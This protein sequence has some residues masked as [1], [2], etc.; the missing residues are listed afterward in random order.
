MRKVKIIMPFVSQAYLA[1]APF[2]EQQ[3]FHKHNITLGYH[4]ETFEDFYVHDADRYK[5]VYIEGKPGSGKS[6]E[7]QNMVLQDAA[8]GRA[9]IVIDPHMDLVDKCIATLDP[10]VLPRVFVLDMTDEQY[11]FGI[12][13]FNTAAFTSD[14]DKTQVVDRI[15]HIFELLWPDVLSQANL[16]RYLRHI[17]LVFLDNPGATLP[18]MYDFL[19]DDGYRRKLLANVTDKGVRQFWQFNYDSLQPQTRLG[20][21]QPL[22]GRL[23]QMFSG[24]QLVKNI[25][26]QQKNSINFREAIEE[27]RIIF[28]KLPLKIVPED[29]RLIGTL[30][31][32]QIH[33]TLFSF[34]DIPDG[35]RPGVS[36]FIDEFQNFVTNDVAELITQGRKYG[37]RITI[38][39]QSR[40][41]L[42]KEM[43][44]AT[45][46]THTQVVFQSTPED[47]RELAHLFPPPNEGIKPEDIDS[48]PTETLAAHAN[49]YPPAIQDFIEWYV[50][51]IGLQAVGAHGN[52]IDIRDAGHSAFSIA[53]DMLDGGR[54]QSIK[55][56]NPIPVLDY[57]LQ[58]VMVYGDA[59]FPIPAAAVRGFANC[60]HTFWQQVAWM[61]DKNKRLHRDIAGLRVPAHLAVQTAEGWQWTRPPDS[62]SEQ[63]LHLLFHIR[64][65]M[66]YL[67][68]HPLGKETTVSTADVGKMLNQLP[69]RCAWVRSG[70]HTG[71]IFTNDTPQPDGTAKDRMDYVRDHTRDVY[72]VDRNKINQPV[73]STTQAGPKVA[74]P[75]PLQTTPP[76]PIADDD[77]QTEP[78]LPVVKA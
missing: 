45:M 50:L 64:A 11:P 6:G 38:A 1:A 8:A 5:A 20:K 66:Q 49:M 21:V 63:L 35:K 77:E 16:P 62:A 19:L 48:H 37:M 53:S 36:L 43:R 32:A 58:M 34:V 76:A 29:A 46:N 69:P 68:A 23:E 25:L 74:N 57:L 72:C 24:R 51:P 30:I 78:R 70:S 22:L 10:M 9:V 60:G 67:A 3:A 2:A 44:G 12:N 17:M 71:T 15:F 13:V 33:A 7:M 42:S 75:Q 61:G 54:V 55:V 41:Q 52:M 4:P 18:D 28:V 39:H 26:G 59:T 56:E 31:V 65:T 14:M 47:G 27:K 40:D 73:N